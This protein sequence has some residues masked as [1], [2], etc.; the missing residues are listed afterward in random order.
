MFFFILKISLTLFA[1]REAAARPRKN[2]TFSFRAFPRFSTRPLHC[3]GKGFAP[4]PPKTIR[5]A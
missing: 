2:F 1:S 3:K 5:E 4:C